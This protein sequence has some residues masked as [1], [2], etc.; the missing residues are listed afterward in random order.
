M[1]RTANLRFYPT[2]ETFESL[3]LLGRDR[4]LEYLMPY[5]EQCRSSRRISGRV[6]E[7]AFQDGV[8]VWFASAEGKID[9][10]QSRPVFG[11]SRT[12][13]RV[14]PAPTR[15]HSV[16]EASNGIVRDFVSS[17]YGIDV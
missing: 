10:H 8:L 3:L 9:A 1:E 2:A 17:A 4:C 12:W 5:L 6:A 11:T 7:I 15:R 16:F 14:L 13:L